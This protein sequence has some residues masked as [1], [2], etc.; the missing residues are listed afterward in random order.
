MSIVSVNVIVACSVNTRVIGNGGKMPWHLP[1]D[2]NYFKARTENGI[3]IMGRKTYESIGKAL[4]N[5]INIVI[6]R[7][8]KYIHKVDKGVWCV[9][10]YEE[11]L[12]IASTFNEKETFV[13]GGGQLYEMAMKGPI[14]YLYVTWVSN[15]DGSS[16]EGDTVFPQIDYDRFEGIDM[17]EHEEN[18]YK[19]LFTTYKDKDGNN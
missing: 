10:S 14:N 4:P 15:K 3:V 8:P 7:D 11:A 16:I 5:R 18:N 9:H 1:T 6:S 17:C 19:L 13:I 2:L 12:K